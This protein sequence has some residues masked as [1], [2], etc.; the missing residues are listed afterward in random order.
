MTH[1]L[2]IRLSAFGDV[3]LVAPV[4]KEVAQANPAVQFTMAAPPL[5]KPLF[6][7]LPNVSFLGVKKHQPTVDIYRQLKSVEADTVADLHQVNRVGHA[8]LLLRLN[9]LL[10][11][12]PLKIRRIHKGR[13]SRWLFLH[14]LYMK[15]RKSQAERYADV[16]RHLG[17]SVPLQT[18]TQILNHTS[19]QPHTI[20]I[21]PFAQHRGKIWPLENTCRLALLL[22][23][24]GYRVFLFGS[25]DEA[26]QLE[27]LAA[28]HENI[29]SL[30]G[31]QS[32]AEELIIMQNLNLMVSM[33][34]ANMHFASVLGTPVVSI[35]GATHPDFGFYGYHQNR[36]NALYSPLPCHPCSAYGNR[37][38]RYGDYR[39]LT[40]IT[41]QQVMHKIEEALH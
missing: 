5:L 27:A 40:A 16:F 31:K 38:C 41:P 39:C 19:T 34:S 22:A 15:P 4:L 10:H 37:R 24:R 12:H 17:L 28:Q 1:V 3:A 36:A 32:F 25:Q 2:V 20:G 14:H 8:L 11:F 13:L 35:W 33:D 18:N 29:E 23:Q 21:A 7:G 9:S 30:A 6:D 26:Q